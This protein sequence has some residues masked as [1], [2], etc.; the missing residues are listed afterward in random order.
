MTSLLSICL[1]I[2]YLVCAKS[3]NERFMRIILDKKFKNRNLSSCSDIL[4]QPDHFLKVIEISQYNQTIEKAPHI[5][6]IH[7]KN[8]V[9]NTIFMGSDK[10]KHDLV[11]VHR[12]ISHN[13]ENVVLDNVCYV[14]D[15]YDHP[16]VLGQNY[17]FES[18]QKY[19]V[20]NYSI[21]LRNNDKIRSGICV[22]KE[23]ENLNDFFIL[24]RNVDDKIVI[25]AICKDVRDLV[26]HVLKKD[27]KR[28]FWFR[29]LVMLIF[30]FSV[31]I[32]FW[33]VLVR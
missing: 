29:I 12:S 32:D 5:H 13:I 26:K 30:V 15:V 28:L 6:I 33:F 1:L 24:T 22:L 7:S 2:K 16:S 23:S 17:E 27:I 25:E 11:V 8:Y 14:D 20:N 4:T 19:L 18:L 10:I 31:I 21:N 9:G 3:H